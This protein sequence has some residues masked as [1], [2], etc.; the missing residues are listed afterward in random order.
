[1]RVLNTFNRNKN[2]KNQWEWTIYLKE[3]S[4]HSIKTSDVQNVKYYLHK[5]FSNDIA[6][7]QNKSNSFQIYGS[8]WGEFLIGAEL[9][10]EEAARIANN[11]KQFYHALFWLNLD[12]GHTKEEKKGYQGIFKEDKLSEDDIKYIRES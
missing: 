3:S 1:M 8:G 10:T 7:S 2:R 9:E 4:D 12:F 11:F 5:S 6:F